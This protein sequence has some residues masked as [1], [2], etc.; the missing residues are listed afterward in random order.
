VKL[1]LLSARP[2]T[3]SNRRLVEAAAGLGAALEVL[4]G[5]ALVAASAGVPVDAGDARFD[6]LPDV[7]LARVGNWRPESL[8][9]L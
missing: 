2:D 8:L 4:D 3:A 6:R 7:V 1:W 5:T 9:A